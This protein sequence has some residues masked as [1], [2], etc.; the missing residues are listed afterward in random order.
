MAGFRIEGNTSGNVV[1]VNTS[2]QLKI[3]PETNAASNP[4]NVG[5]V[6]MFSE[7]DPGEISGSAYLRS[8]E[9]SSDYRLRAAVDTV[10]FT[11]T[12]NATAQNTG[13]WKHAFTTMTMTQSAGFLNVNAAGTSTVSGNYAY[14]QTWKYFPMIGTAPLSI[15]VTCALTSVALQ[16][17]EVYQWGAGVALA[18]ADPVDGAWFELTTA[19]LY[20]VIRYNSGVA[21]KQ[22]LTATARTLGANNKYVLVLAEREVE[23]WI[24]DVFY[25]EIAIPTGQSQPLLTTALPVFIQKYNNGTV[26]ASP[27]SILKVGDITTSLMDIATFKPWS[28]QM[29]GQG[30]SG[31]GQNGGTM[32]PN[33]FFTNSAYP[34]TALP[35]NTALTANLPTGIGGGRGLATLWNLAA[36]DMVLTQATNPLGGVNQ[37]P[38]TLF[39]TGVTINAVSHSAAWTG[40][41]AGGHSLLFGV[42]YGSTAVTLAQAETGSFVTA[43]IK[44]FRRKLLGFMTWATGATAVG[45]PPDRG[46]IVVTFDSPIVVNPGENFGIFAQMTNGAVTAT[47][48]LFFTYDFDHYYQ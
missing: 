30:Y 38:R 28:Q 37:T 4:G 7:N 48:G 41:A 13:M 2:N 12:F 6:R 43:T 44:A 46:P 42:Y 17:N 9:T 39:I 14:L 8:P 15:E 16:A 36:T 18:A 22:I 10:L 3:V 31:Q 34:T 20:G 32:G 35:I 11:D 23:F 29:A 19:G 33:A 1:E 26:G 21:T 40:P 24:D 45:T 27:S 25:G 5:G 47:G